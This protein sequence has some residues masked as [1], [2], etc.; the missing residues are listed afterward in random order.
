MFIKGFYFFRYYL[1]NV[2]RYAKGHLINQ[3]FHCKYEFIPSNIRFVKNTNLAY[4]KL[5]ILKANGHNYLRYEN[6]DIDI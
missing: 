2:K 6:D 5:N 1:K 3:P 4:I